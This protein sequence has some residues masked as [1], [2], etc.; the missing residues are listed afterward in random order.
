MT[1]LSE[2]V[3]AEFFQHLSLA[4]TSLSVPHIP[5]Y[6]HVNWEIVPIA[7]LSTCRIP[8]AGVNRMLGVYFINVIG[9]PPNASL[10]QKLQ[11]NV[12]TLLNV[13]LTL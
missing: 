7:R 8:D 13:I 1:C 10:S 2:V 9:R 4:E 3:H 11:Q 12:M 5:E 6:K